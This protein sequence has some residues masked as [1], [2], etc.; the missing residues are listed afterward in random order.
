MRRLLLAIVLCV[1]V[2]EV[3]AQCHPERSEGPAL[4]SSEAGR[5]RSLAALGMTAKGAIARGLIQG[6]SIERH[7]VE[8]SLAFAYR[9]TEFRPRAPG[10]D[11]G[12]AIWP[13]YLGD[14]VLA[15]TLDLGL[16]QSTPVGGSLLFLR[17][18]GGALVLVGPV[19]A[20]S[21]PR[22]RPASRW[23]CRST[24]GLRSG[25][26]W[27]ST[28]TGSIASSSDAGASGSGSRCSRT[29]GD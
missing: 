24:R 15:S 12:I 22:S 7:Q 14:R 16:A 9:M 21:C 29:G 17:G 1:L 18:G 8:G 27:A 25:S 26:T 5:T 11:L 28:G 13:R 3:K 6:A 4:P 10:L 23:W 2:G 19:A 20:A